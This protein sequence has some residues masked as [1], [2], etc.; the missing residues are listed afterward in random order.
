MRIGKYVKR[1]SLKPD[2]LRPV[3]PRKSS[4]F[5]R[6]NKHLV[7]SPVSVHVKEAPPQVEEPPMLEK[8]DFSK[9]DDPGHETV[10][11]RLSSHVDNRGTDVEIKTI[12]DT[13]L[14]NIDED[15]TNIVSAVPSGGDSDAGL[16]SLHEATTENDQT[17][18]VEDGVATN[19]SP[20][21]GFLG[22][23]PAVLME[24]HDRDVDAPSSDIENLE[25]PREHSVAS[26]RAFKTIL[27]DKEHTAVTLLK[28]SSPAEVA[29]DESQRS[30]IIGREHALEETS[31]NL[32]LPIPA[33]PSAENS[34]LNRSN[35]LEDAAWVESQRIRINRTSPTKGHHRGSAEQI[36]IGGSE[37]SHQ[38][39]SVATE[40]SLSI[41][42]LEGDWSASGGESTSAE[43]DTLD[44]P[45]TRTSI[46]LAET[47]EPMLYH[48]P[49]E[50]ERVELQSDV[51]TQLAKDEDS[52]T[53]DPEPQTNADDAQIKEM[54][55][56][57]NSETTQEQIE[58]PG[59]RTRSVT[60]FSDDTKML[61]DFVNRVQA[62]KAAKGLQIPVYVAAPMTSPRRSPR[63]ALAEVDKNS[64]SPRKPHDLAN[65]PGTPPGDGKL[66]SIDYDDLDDI[67]AT[68]TSC[69]RSTR[70]RLFAPSTTAAGA[71]SLIPVR[72]AD[73]EA[74]VLLQKSQAQELAMV[75][76]ANT[77]RNKGQSKPPKV[78][79]QTLPADASEDGI[80]RPGER[81]EARAVGWDERL[82]YFQDRSE[83]KEGK[84][85]KRRKVRRTRNVGAT[86]GTP[87]RKKPVPESD[88]SN[89]ASVARGRSK[90]KGKFMK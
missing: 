89:G 5:K 29:S 12:S 10:E 23:L 86:N 73:G 66:G 71:P 78:T 21:E 6:P 26:P 27:S 15:V 56:N 69:R 4:L 68:Q 36:I 75:T 80:A 62:R 48:G 83:W 7:L 76:R 52:V 90:S 51:S 8:H 60:R 55:I 43:D 72:R 19:P 42:S 24:A 16:I 65:R 22:V 14:V 34:T 32:V 28:M 44:E 57:E 50:T 35:S 67:A 87:A 1:K 33:D 2:R 38:I 64:P 11:S 47:C 41:D 84:A 31:K 40:E 85:E 25:S 74:I 39:E 77:K 49:S 79:L 20:T 30:R 63:K 53:E 58:G 61:K 37:P 59:R 82:V 70:T 81:G 18:S 45:S 13:P 46:L 88:S 3:M 9:S 54:E 17:T